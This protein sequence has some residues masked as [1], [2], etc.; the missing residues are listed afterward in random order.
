MHKGIELVQNLNSEVLI[1][2]MNFYS[3]ELEAFY[4]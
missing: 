3:N 2:K 1:Q 4:H